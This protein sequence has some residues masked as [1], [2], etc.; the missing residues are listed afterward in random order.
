MKR[1]SKGRFAKT[2]TLRSKIE[3]FIFILLSVGLL[4]FSL[5]YKVDAY[6]LDYYGV[7]APYTVE[8]DLY[9]E[10]RQAEIAKEQKKAT[11]DLGFNSNNDGWVEPNQLTLDS[12]AEHTDCTERQILMRLSH[13]ESTQRDI[14]NE[15]GFCGKYQIGAPAWS[16]CHRMNIHDESQCALYH[17]TINPHRFEAY[18]RNENSFSGI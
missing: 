7:W 12:I 15:W 6:P 2:Y 9:H 16:D 4:L 5:N 18:T 3:L 10:E 17:Y 1:D 14:C 8:N 13:Y 11:C